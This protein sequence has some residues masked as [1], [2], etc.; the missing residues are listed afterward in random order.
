MVNDFKMM[1][2]KKCTDA[3]INTPIQR[4]QN[5]NDF[6]NLKQ[7]HTQQEEEVGVCGV[8]HSVK[9][10]NQQRICKDTTKSS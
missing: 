7:D 6:S 5:R 2:D 10:K 4:V 9:R 3:Y 8:R 1:S